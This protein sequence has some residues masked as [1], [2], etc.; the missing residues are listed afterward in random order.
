[1][2][3]VETTSGEDR[4]AALVA[5][6]A[7][8]EELSKD[9]AEQVARFEAENPE[10]AGERGLWEGLGALGDPREGE[11][12]MSDAA[13][14]ERVLSQ[15][16]A[17]EIP[18]P[19]RPRA[20]PLVR[21]GVA[22]AFAG[23]A[24]AAALVLAIAA[25]LVSSNK[26]PP[27]PEDESSGQNIEAPAPHPRGLTGQNPA[28]VEVDAG[29]DAAVAPDP[30]PSEA[31]AAATTTEL[32]PSRALRPDDAKHAAAPSRDGHPAGAPAPESAD[33]LLKSAQVH[34]GEGNRA[35]AIDAYNRL[36]ARY[37]GSVEARVALVSLG[38]L[39][40]GGGD[41]AAALSYF[42]RYLAGAGPLGM[43]A[44]YGRIQALRRLGRA[45]DELAAIQDF[46]TRYPESVH[47]PRLRARLE[48]VPA[49]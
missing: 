40:L 43:E 27:P 8:G 11:P 38:Q 7:R 14:L 34:L 20:R 29:A 16:R 47:A 23:I 18:P 17:A 37:P 41:A 49:K 25:E 26:P 4:W 24:L 35:G 3:A 6:Q 39:S 33:A 10:V 36:L 21:R 31:A 13:M 30:A 15:H 46:L 1:M 5:R 45:G 28:D 44:R 32:D 9:E 12:E 42:D 19:A 48:A 2:S 22:G